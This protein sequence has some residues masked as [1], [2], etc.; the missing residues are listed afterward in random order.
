MPARA[1]A[2]LA[3]VSGLPGGW[4][5]VGLARALVG[6][7]AAR[8]ASVGP[9]GEGWSVIV[10]IRGLIVRESGLACVPCPGWC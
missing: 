10:W 6:Q 7:R 8:G 1:L 9:L 4:Y 2:G 5:Q 3:A